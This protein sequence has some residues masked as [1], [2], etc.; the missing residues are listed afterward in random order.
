M[1]TDPHELASRRRSAPRRGS[2][3]GAPASRERRPT[4]RAARPRARPRARGSRRCRRRCGCC[5]WA[6]ARRLRAFCPRRRRRRWCGGRGVGGVHAARVRSVVCSVCGEARVDTRRARARPPVPSH[7][8][9]CLST[10]PQELL[11][12]PGASAE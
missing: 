9:L 3:R 4:L 10:C 6:R 12:P 7:L 8:R 11:E 2:Q 1:R 5:R